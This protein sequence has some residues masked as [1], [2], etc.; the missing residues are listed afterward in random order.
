[1]D[2]DIISKR[3]LLDLIVDC[4]LQIVCRHIAHQ[5]FCRVFTLLFCRSVVAEQFPDPIL[6]LSDIFTRFWRIKNA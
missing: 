3:D 6:A 1:M 2:E 5:V 4:L